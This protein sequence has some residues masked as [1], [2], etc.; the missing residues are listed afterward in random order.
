[1]EAMNCIMF[2]SLQYSGIRQSGNDGGHEHQNQCVADGLWVGG[3]SD[4]G[5]DYA[6]LTPLAAA[7]LLLS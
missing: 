1:M 2:C 7:G 3:A 6:V 4:I 5:Q